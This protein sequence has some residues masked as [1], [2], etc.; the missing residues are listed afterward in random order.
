M[1][2]QQEKEQNEKAFNTMLIALRPDLASLSQALDLTGVD[3]EILRQTVY[4]LERIVGIGGTN[5]GNVIIQI[6]N[7][8]VTFIRG[9]ASR[10]LNLSV[11]KAPVDSS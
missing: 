3:A 10:K 4:A 7:G 9:E 11:L 2:Y 6:E 1:D 5:Y 8:V